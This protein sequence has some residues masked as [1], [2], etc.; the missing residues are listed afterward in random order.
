MPLYKIL[1][2]LLFNKENKRITNF[3]NLTTGLYYFYSIILLKQ[4]ELH[5]HD[6][7]NRLLISITQNVSYVYL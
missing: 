3:I 6:Y 5:K 7:S 4:D 1:N 2:K